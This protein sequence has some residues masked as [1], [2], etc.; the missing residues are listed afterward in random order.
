MHG[1][2]EV[3]ALR[4]NKLPVS[5]SE[6]QRLSKQPARMLL[7]KAV[8]LRYLRPGTGALASAINMVFIVPCPRTSFL[9]YT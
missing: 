7:A 6:A 9:T 1:G 3:G 8:K 2:V 4:E 5:F